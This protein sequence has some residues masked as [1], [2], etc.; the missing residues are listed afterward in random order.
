MIDF[1]RYAIPLSDTGWQ[2]SGE[3]GRFMR[4]FGKMG[5]AVVVPSPSG[6][7]WGWAIQWDR[8]EHFLSV[9][10]GGVD[11]FPLVKI[12]RHD[13][14]ERN[15]ERK[16]GFGTPLAAMLDV[17]KQLGDEFYSSF[18]YGPGEGKFTD[19]EYTDQTF[20][21]MISGF[22]K[23]FPLTEEVDKR[24]RRAEWLF[25]RWGD[26]KGVLHLDKGDIEACNEEIRGDRKTWYAVSWEEKRAWFRAR[27]LWNQEHQDVIDKWRFQ[28][29]RCEE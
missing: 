5:A 10:R 29:V 2:W 1:A 3:H 22:N 20:Q 6:D 27:G 4:S 8:Q 17:E 14:D 28:H 23:D 19:D 7:G 16:K 12:Y 13:A 24:R 25:D 26:Y 9:N 11:V 18:S 21:L 15:V